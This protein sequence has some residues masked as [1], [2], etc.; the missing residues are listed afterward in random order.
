MAVAGAQVAGRELVGAGQGVLAPGL[1]VAV[2]G[3]LAGHLL[4]PVHHLVL[5]GRF[6]DARVQ[7]PAVVEHVNPDDAQNSKQPQRNENR[8]VKRQHQHP[9]H[10]LEPGKHQVN[11]QLGEALLH[12]EDVEKAVHQLG[13]V[14]ALQGCGLNARQAIG[15]L[16][17]RLSKQPLLDGFHQHHLAQQ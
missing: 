6:L 7:R 17:G 11:Q 1:V 10:N 4:Q 3:Q 13:R 5:I 16:D 2:G 9:K 12:R 15:K 8:V 14:P